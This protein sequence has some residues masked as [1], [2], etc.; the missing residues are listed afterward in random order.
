M[1]LRSLRIDRRALLRERKSRPLRARTRRSP[2]RST[3]KRHDQR[4]TFCRK[5]S[6]QYSTIRASFIGRE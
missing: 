5:I 3:T 4:S 2:S 6:N 1:L